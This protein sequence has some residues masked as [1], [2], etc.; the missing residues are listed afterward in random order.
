M[1]TKIKHGEGYRELLRDIQNY[2]V[3][4][5]GIDEKSMAFG[6]ANFLNEVAKADNYDD[7]A[8]E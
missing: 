8:E 5:Q 3:A 4:N 1:E 6:L 2:L 7:G